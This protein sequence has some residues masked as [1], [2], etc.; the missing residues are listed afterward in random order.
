[1][2]KPKKI[3]IFLVGLSL[4]F[5]ILGGI[6]VLVISL[7]LPKLDNMQDYR[8]ALGSVVYSKDGKAL[9]EFYDI[10]R[11]YLI[12]VEDISENTI[13]A[14]IAAE[15][16]GFFNHGGI[17]FLGILRA[18]WANIRAGQVVQGGSTITMQVSKSLLLSSERTYGRKFK[19]VLLASKVEKNFSKMQILNL[20]LNQIYFGQRAYGIEAAARSYFRKTAKDLD[21]HEAALLAGL[22]KA[23]SAYSPLRDPLRARERQLYVLRRMKDTG[24]I[25]E[26][27]FEK[28][29]IIPTKVYPEDN[30]NIRVAPYYVE[31]VR[32]LVGAKYG[33]E[34]VY[35]NGLKIEVAAD[36]ELSEKA[37]KS[38]KGNLE[39]LDKRQGYRG[40]LSHIST[41]E[42]LAEERLKSLDQVI[43]KKYGYKILP[44]EVAA[45]FSKT[46]WS[47][48]TLEQIEKSDANAAK[49]EELFVPTENYRAVV[50]KIE[51]DGKSATVGIG[52]YEA[53]LN[54]SV[55]RWAKRIRE[56]ETANY[57]QISRIQDS[58]RVGDVILVRP[59]LPFP[60]KEDELMNVSL[61]Q[62]PIAQSALLSLEASTG[63]V[64]AMVGG[65][66]F[67]NSQYNRALQGERQPGSSFKPL[68][69]S[70]A[71]DKGFNASSII[72]DSP[73]IFENQSGGT[74]KWIPENNSEKFYGDT[75]LRT[76]I[77]NSRNVPAVKILQEIG[78]KYF[79]NYLK[80]VGV[81]GEINPDLSL[82]L[83]SKGISLL[84]LTKLYALYPRLGQRIEP[85]F[86]LKITDRDGHVL[87]E[88]S[89][90][91]YQR[92]LT[93]KWLEKK[94]K[95]EVAMNNEK[96]IAASEAAIDHQTGTQMRNPDLP[97]QFDDPLR[98]IDEKTA[99]LMSN[100]LQEVVQYGTATP[101]R[102][103]KRK[104]G[105]KT[106]TTNE[107]VDAW[108]MGFSAEIVTGV[109]TGFD[110]P[111]SLGM[112][113]VGSRAALPAWIDYM[114][115][116]LEKYTKDEY[117]VPKG[118]VFVRIDP[119][120]GN[121]ATGGNASGIKEAYIEGTEPTFSRQNQQTPDSSDFFREDL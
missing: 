43:E 115:A 33:L 44:A 82:A 53:K 10:E 29:L 73:I 107:F 86:I 24:K 98:A 52:P 94:S 37:K 35:T 114:S 120:T 69:Y 88:Y 65:Y 19:E 42:K 97:P 79:A 2:L 48:Y 102:I 71:L 117:T 83:G 5:A 70:A 40:P 90:Q 101:A 55:M 7:N 25:S 50:L 104:V 1:M 108:F 15:D 92:E 84:E 9:G 76:A 78:L 16:D 47:K 87:E 27:E 106:G 63:S 85:V 118:I 105:G 38:V 12:N 64:V 75:T 46:N 26:E 32:Q 18:F 36:Y 93:A 45:D 56:N 3:A 72:V 30:P 39:D 17:D 8:P 59:Q 121:L 81:Q 22:V 34:F 119:K 116:A 28:Q 61:E 99:F 100:L 111:R 80:Y 95:D 77:I 49:V 103:L 11:R 96:Q 74:L 51:K 41:E 60:K 109:W 110:N 91:E 57:A 68:L 58:L 67:E 14:F 23:P 21:I 13:N 31:H 20:Y 113:E 4:V 89:Y 54:L 112:G 66:N 6:F 62:T